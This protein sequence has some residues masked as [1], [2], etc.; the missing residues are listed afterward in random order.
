[1]D[2][3]YL[4]PASTLSL[5]NITAVQIFPLDLSHT[6]PD[7]DT[8]NHATALFAQPRGRSKEELILGPED[9]HSGF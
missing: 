6:V 2:L 1:M 3:I 8:C 9:F 4:L 7:K 5:H